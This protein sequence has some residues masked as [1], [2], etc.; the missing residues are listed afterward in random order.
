MK[1][2]KTHQKKKKKKNPLEHHMR[3][4]KL[5]NNLPFS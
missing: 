4:V 2:Q 3:I 5:Y 1:T